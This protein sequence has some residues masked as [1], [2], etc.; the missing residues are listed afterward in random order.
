MSSLGGF[1]RSRL[2]GKNGDNESLSDFSGINGA[3]GGAFSTSKMLAASGSK[4]G[5]LHNK[6]ND[7]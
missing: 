7:K 5:A 2:G 4:S 1:M 6:E 3:F